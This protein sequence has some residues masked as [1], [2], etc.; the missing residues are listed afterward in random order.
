MFSGGYMG[1][2]MI[3]PGMGIL[4]FIVILVILYLFVVSFQHNNQNHKSA[5]NSMEILK[6][7]YARGEIS[8]EEYLST[9]DVLKKD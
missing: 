9:R 1:N 4:M 5:D 6:N 3:F 2:A 7:R 8:K